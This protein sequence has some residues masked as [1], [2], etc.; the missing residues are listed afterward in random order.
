MWYILLQDI[1]Y[2]RWKHISSF[3]IKYSISFYFFQM[4]FVKYIVKWK[5][6]KNVWRK[7]D[8]SDFSDSGNGFSEF[9]TGKRKTALLIQKEK[10][11][12]GITF[13]IGHKNVGSKIQANVMELFEISNKETH[14]QIL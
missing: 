6:Y 12:K 7:I 5:P 11:P 1:V 14:M 13:S 2:Y 9:Y 3:W 8:S 4:L 10:L